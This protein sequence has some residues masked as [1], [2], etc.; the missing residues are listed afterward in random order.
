MGK[1]LAISKHVNRLAPSAFYQ[2]VHSTVGPNGLAYDDIAETYIVTSYDIAVEILNDPDGFSKPSKPYKLRELCQSE[3]AKAGLENLSKSLLFFNSPDHRERNS[4]LAK[5]LGQSKVL[6]EAASKV[7]KNSV[8][9]II[10]NCCIGESNIYPILQDHVHQLA[11]RTFGLSASADLLKLSCVNH[12]VSLLDGKFKSKL[13]I[14]HGLESLNQIIAAIS[15]HQQ[16]NNLSENDRIDMA[17]CF[18][19]AHESA[20]YQI[21]NLMLYAPKMVSNSGQVTKV[22]NEAL[23]IDPP[24]QVLTKTVSHMSGVA[25]K[26]GFQVGDRVA[27]HLGAASNDSRVFKNPANFSL[28][29]NIKPI[30]FGVGNTRCPGAGFSQVFIRKF[31]KELSGSINTINVTKIT[32]NHGLNGRGLKSAFVQVF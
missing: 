12:V 27:I 15:R 14:C 28:T 2:F 25:K 24:I 13:E 23:R 19:A 10:Q 29:R 6:D 32:P 3:T 5:Y 20:A 9:E 17:V 22:M 26:H 21:I 18:V 11:L 4:K 7:A 31:L 1:I 30:F 8:D 16:Y